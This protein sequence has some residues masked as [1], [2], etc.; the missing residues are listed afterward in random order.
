M[1]WEGLSLGTLVNETIGTAAIAGNIETGATTVADIG[2]TTADADKELAVATVAKSQLNIGQ[3][4]VP[5]CRTS[6]PPIA[7]AA[8]WS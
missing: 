1:E 3:V 6:G 8:G 7:L 5:R 4:S 2:I